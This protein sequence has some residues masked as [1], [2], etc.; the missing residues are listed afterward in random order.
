MPQAAGAVI[1]AAGSIIG[2]RK[3]AGAASDAARAQTAIGNRQLDMQEQIYNDTNR[4]FQPFLRSGKNALRAYNFEMGLGPRPTFGGTAPQIESFNNG[5]WGAYSP[6][7]SQPASGG[8]GFG[9]WAGRAVEGLMGDGRIA[10]GGI[11]PSMGGQGGGA[12]QS[13]GIS[14]SMGGG[15]SPF[16]P[17]PG[18]GQAGQG[19][20]F[21]VGGKQFGTIEEAQKYA[22]ANRTGGTE[23]AGYQAS[24]GYKWQLEQGTAAIDASAAARGGLMSGRTL[25]DL[26]AYGQGL[27]DQDREAYLSRLGGLVDS[28]Q[29]AAGSQATAGANYAAG[30]GNALA[31]IG[32]A[33]SAGIIGRGNAYSGMI[34]G[35]SQ[36][37]GYMGQNW[38]GLFGGQGQS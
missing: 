20:Q 31:G 18:G 32:N 15:I 3:Q 13:G 24:P 1:G 38:G 8:G 4:K 7:A 16:M 2:G 9:D 33:Q 34:N 12:A 5:A 17:M 10:Q 28:G 11:S 35:L 27:A 30:A 37:A 29:G 36:T 6:S 25:Q 21:R 14:P 23:Y 26:Q 19:G 22:N